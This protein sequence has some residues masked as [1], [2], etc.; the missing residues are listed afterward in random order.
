MS[1]FHGAELNS[2]VEIGEGSVIRC[3]KGGKLWFVDGV[4]VVKSGEDEI[5][6]PPDSPTPATILKDICFEN[7]VPCISLK[8]SFEITSIE[9]SF[10]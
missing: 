7:P 9:L 10:L 1:G 2:A 4:C 8:G 3:S 6:T 5:E